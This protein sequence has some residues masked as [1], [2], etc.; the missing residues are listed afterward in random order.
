V[1]DRTTR[2]TDQAP[3]ATAGRPARAA[4]LRRADD[5]PTGVGPALGADEELLV[6]LRGIGAMMFLTTERVIVARD[7][8]ERRPRTG[9]QSFRLDEIRQI[10]LELGSAPSGRIAISTAAGQESVSMFFDARSLDRA[11]GLIDIARPL[12]ARRRRS[13]LGAGPV[14]RPPNGRADSGSPDSA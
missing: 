14:R 7:G 3:R 9:I 5:R 6:V 4:D 10:R 1:A 12:I 13:G 2:T 11:H 8:L